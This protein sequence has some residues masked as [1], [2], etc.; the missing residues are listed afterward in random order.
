MLHI[1]I[2]VKAV[3]VLQDAIENLDEMSTHIM[4]TFDAAFSK[5]Q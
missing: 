3:K 1:A 2:G 5:A 4:A